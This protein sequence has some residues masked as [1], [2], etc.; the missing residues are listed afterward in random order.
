MLTATGQPLIER[1]AD[2]IPHCQGGNPV[3]QLGDRVV[4]RLPRIVQF[5]E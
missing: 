2:L 3:R 5:A 1:I 4:R